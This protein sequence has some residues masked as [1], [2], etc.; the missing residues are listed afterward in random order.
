M[1]SSIPG[2]RKTVDRLP[3]LPLPK[4]IDPRKDG[5]NA[6][7]IA[8]V[9]D[10]TRYLNEASWPGHYGIT[11]R[12]ANRLVERALF[13]G[14]A[15]RLHRDR[16]ALD[17]DFRLGRTAGFSVSFGNRRTV[18]VAPRPTGTTVSAGV[19]AIVLAGLRDRFAAGLFRF[20]VVVLIRII[21]VRIIHLRLV[22][23]RTLTVA[24]AVI[25]A[26]STVIAKTLAVVDVQD[27]EIVL[28]MLIHV[29]RHDPIAG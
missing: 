26:V 16:Y 8:A 22:V 10:S 13:G 1:V 25:A 15:F 3:T 21:V 4:G 17:D 28:R 6:T 29:F 23:A 12:A 5:G 11:R 27:A 24:I 18:I 20:R 9:T 19:V 14:I 2:S 7:R